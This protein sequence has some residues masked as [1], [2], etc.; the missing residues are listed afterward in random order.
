MYFC[1]KISDYRYSE[2]VI[3]YAMRQKIIILALVAV[4]ALTGAALGA[5]SYIFLH[6]NSME[7]EPY[8]I[9]VDEDDTA[10]SICAKSGLGW[11]FGFYNRFMSFRPRTGHYIVEPGVRS[12]ELFRKLRNGAQDPIKLTVP[13]VRTLSRLAAYLGNQLM[14]DS[15][16]FATT[17]AQE[18]EGMGYTMETLPALFIPNTYEMY[19]DVS[20]KSFMKRMEKEN[21]AFWNDKREAKARAIG[22][23]HVEV[24]T[25]ASIVEEETA[26]DGEKPM[27]AGLYLNR[28]RRGML[29]QADPTVKF[30]MQAFGL[31]RIYNEHLRYE[32]PYNTYLHP[33]LPPGPIRLPSI[34]GLD[35]VLNYVEHTYIYM[36]AKEDF[37]GTH[38]YATTYAEHLRNARR[39]VQALNNRGIK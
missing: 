8:S 19:W 5:Y 10:D 14:K 30:A 6:K 33:G 26:N 20:A 15:A 37:S 17:F 28:L 11:R 32:S 9:Y 31:R 34:V 1:V 2:S 24:S 7:T 25:L 38:N 22:L 23:S 3:N 29:L 36:C 4:A 35:A 18:A 16:D 21:K 27:V 13:S 12:L 39:Y